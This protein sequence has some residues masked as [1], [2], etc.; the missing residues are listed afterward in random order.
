MKLIVFIAVISFFIIPDNCLAQFANSNSALQDS[1]GKLS[2]EIWKQKSESDRLAASNT[3]FEH[4]QKVLQSSNSTA[5]PLDSVPGITR[6]ASEDGKIRIYTWNVPLADGTNKYFGFI[7]IN[8]IA[9]VLIP[10]Q[11]VFYDVNDF[12]IAT[13]TSQN[14]YGALYYKLIEVNTG[15]KTFYTLLGWDG[16]TKVANRKIIDI[17]SFDKDSQIIFGMPVFKTESGVKSRVVF[18][19]ADRANML[20]RYDY[21]AIKVQK[22]KKIKKESAWLIVMDRLVPMDPTLKDFRK[23][24]VPAGDTYDG[25]IFRNSNWVLVEDIEVGNK[26]KQQQ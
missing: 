9:S 10:L 1:L 21:Q 15:D 20:L 23:Y 24:Y 13:F 2:S 17:I 7:Q 22:K 4:F 8:T 6:A 12:S 18:E 26:E 19:Y 11:S 16:F 14:W 25:Y 5:F 3:F